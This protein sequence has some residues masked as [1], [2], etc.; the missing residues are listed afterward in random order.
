MKKVIWMIILMSALSI[1]VKAQASYGDIS[2]GS[3]NMKI[4]V[5]TDN[6]SIFLNIVYTDEKLNLADEPKLLLKLM[7]DEVI[8]LD[9]QLLSNL[10]KSDGGVII[11]GTYISSN[12]FISEAKFPISKEQISQFSKGIKK[13]RLN[14]SPKYHEKEWKKD[15]IGKKLYESYKKSSPNSFEDGF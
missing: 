1:H 15:K 9:G 13:L 10:S 2:W 6:D 4:N 5:I 8:S 12:H 14:T 7:D 3:Y 11:Y